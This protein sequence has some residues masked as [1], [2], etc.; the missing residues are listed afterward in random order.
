LGTVPGNPIE[1]AA[2][3]DS[4]YTRMGSETGSLGPPRAAHQS[5]AGGRASVRFYGSGAIYWTP[6]AGAHAM[7][8]P[9]FQ[10]WL[11][12][13]GERSRLGFPTGD[14]RVSDAGASREQEFE[15]GRITW[16]QRD[17]AAVVYSGQ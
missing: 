13:G 14:E 2:A 3:I 6:G 11:A 1:G 4:E 9:L 17:G 8:G 16:T 12:Q 15:G 7:V 5:T 10:A